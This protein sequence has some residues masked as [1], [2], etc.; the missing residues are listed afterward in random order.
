M[1]IFFCICTLAL[2]LFIFFLN[3]CVF[4]N[5]ELN[6][7]LTLCKGLQNMAKAEGEWYQYFH[8][9]LFTIWHYVGKQQ[10][11]PNIPFCLKTPFSSVYLKWKKLLIRCLQLKVLFWTLTLECYGLIIVY[12]SQ[13]LEYLHTYFSSDLMKS[14]FTLIPK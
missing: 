7:K 4:F 14:Q 1:L 2:K 6:S 9:A 13:C 8:P 5:T 11:K 10:Y 12:L 3:V